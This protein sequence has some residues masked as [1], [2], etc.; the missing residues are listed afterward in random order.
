M[1]ASEV[2]V[3]V[4]TIR[5]LALEHSTTST[6]PKLT[7]CSTTVPFLTREGTGKRNVRT[8]LLTGNKSIRIV[9]RRH[10]LTGAFWNSKQ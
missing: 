9:P 4:V 7:S 6:S 3:F 1:F 2:G 5:Y 8:V 10:I